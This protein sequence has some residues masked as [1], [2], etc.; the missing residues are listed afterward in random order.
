[1]SSLK[2]FMGMVR[3]FPALSIVIGV[4]SSYWWGWLI[5]YILLCCGVSPKLYTTIFIATTAV[6]IDRVSTYA[7]M[8]MF[9]IRIHEINP[10]IRSC[11][12]KMGIK[13][14]LILSFFH[15]RQL[16]IYF[17]TFSLFYISY[18]ILNLIIGRFLVYIEDIFLLA[19]FS[20]TIFVMLYAIRNLVV[21]YGLIYNKPWL[22]L[23]TGRG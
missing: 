17:V 11:V 6:L 1:M 8:T 23:F 12:K 9:P 15:L 21:L 2:D 13:R 22:M 20:I 16:R 5:G 7:S 19:L 3:F 18:Y 14:G 4:T 10:I